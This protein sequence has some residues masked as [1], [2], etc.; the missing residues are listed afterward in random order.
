[1][2]HPLTS[3]L[4]ALALGLT[5][6]CA[7]EAQLATDDEA[8]I[9]ARCFSKFAQQ[10]I[11]KELQAVTAQEIVSA[12]ECEEFGAFLESI[13]AVDATLDGARGANDSDWNLGVQP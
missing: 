13:Q 5:L 8:E 3:L 2:K 4:S 12:V 6:G 10:D 7:N 1:M 9:R 11:K